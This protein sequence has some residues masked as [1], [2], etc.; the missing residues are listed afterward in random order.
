MLSR[1]RVRSFA[2]GE[3]KLRF[4]IIADAH[5]GP[6]GTN[7]PPVLGF[8]SV[9]YEYERSDAI[10]RYRHA[11]RRCVQ[12][13]VD[14]LLLLGD[15]SWSGDRES[16]EVGVRLAAKTGR[17]VWTVS[18]NHDCG[19]RVDALARAVR[20]IRADNVR[21]ATLEGEMVGKE[22][23]IAGMSVTSE[24][25]GYTARSGGKPDVSGWGGDLVMWL[26]HYPM[27]SFEEKASQAGLYY[28]DND[29]EDLEEAARPL[30]ERS[31]PTVVVNGHMHMRDACVVG[32]V[33]QVSCAALTQPP[34]EVTFLDFERKGEQ[35][36]VRRESVSVA[37]FPDDVYLPVLSPPK[38]EWI[39][40]A[41]MWCSVEA[42]ELRK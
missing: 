5:L 41:G 1:V 28:G 29:L 3:F 26:S 19:E 36:T 27:I 15:L 31:G 11:L 8:P 6:T 17:P 23:R 13:D 38:Q 2:R 32:E 37:P 16:L 39:F 34:F 40:E 9:P 30:L 14:G 22:L 35:I 24:N 4:G 12:E 33:L 20:W 25:W 42:A 10:M 21:L 18:G 7:F